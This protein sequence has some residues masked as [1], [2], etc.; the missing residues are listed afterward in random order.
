MKTA[1]S[2]PHAGIKEHRSI[3]YANTCN[4]DLIDR[5]NRHGKEATAWK[6]RTVQATVQFD[7]ETRRRKQKECRRH[8][9][10]YRPEEARKRKI[11]ESRRGWKE[12][13]V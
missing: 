5:G 8:C 10:Q 7:P 1:L 13:I 9:S 6:W 11:S 12:K 4:K 2:A 3:R